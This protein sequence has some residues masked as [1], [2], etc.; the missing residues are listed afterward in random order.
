MFRNDK[1]AAILEML[2]VK[3]FLRGVERPIA[4]PRR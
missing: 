1:H 2:V 3:E 4:S